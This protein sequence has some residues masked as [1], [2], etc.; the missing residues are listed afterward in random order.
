M[1]VLL[2]AADQLND[3]PGSKGWSSGFCQSASS[4]GGHSVAATATAASA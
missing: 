4:A 3:R 1:S 2:H